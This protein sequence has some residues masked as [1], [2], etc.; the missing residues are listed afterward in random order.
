MKICLAQDFSGEYRFNTVDGHN[1]TY[2]FNP[3]RQRLLY[4]Q[5]YTNLR[6]N[7]ELVSL[8]I[9]TIN[10]KGSSKKVTI[11]RKYSEY[12][13]CLRCMI[14]TDRNNL[15]FEQGLAFQTSRK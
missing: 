6:S 4:L 2:F 1:I 5:S 14:S 15:R 11:S 12:E 3:K 8:R 10:M 13:Y 7:R 9:V